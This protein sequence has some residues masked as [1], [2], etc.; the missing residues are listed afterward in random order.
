MVEKDPQ[1]SDVS[2]QTGGSGLKALIV[3][4]VLVVVLF[5]IL[6]GFSAVSDLMLF[7]Y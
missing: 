6:A 7:D 1:D 5:G 2:G 3:A 4:A